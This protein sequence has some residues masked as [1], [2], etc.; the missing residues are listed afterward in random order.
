MS[1][2][3]A[4]TMP[5]RRPTARS[6]GWTLLQYSSGSVITVGRTLMSYETPALTSRIHSS[7]T[8]APGLTTQDSDAMCNQ[9]SARELG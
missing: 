5:V 4:L 2:S 3:L 6:H 9:S 7:S 1:S 8:A